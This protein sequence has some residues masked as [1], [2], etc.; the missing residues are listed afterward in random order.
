VAG[1]DDPY[2]AFRHMLSA[3]ETSVNE[4]AK[5]SMGSEGLSK[6]E[7]THGAREAV[8]TGMQRYLAAMNLPSRQEIEA[9]GLRLQSIETQLQRLTQL[10]EGIATKAQAPR[11]GSP[12]PKPRRR[13]RA[14]ET[15][16]ESH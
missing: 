12:P 11:D 5:S 10:V 2:A 16:K 14:P 6:A 1:N 15:G 4:L 3:W 8:E 13:S 7:A 9:I